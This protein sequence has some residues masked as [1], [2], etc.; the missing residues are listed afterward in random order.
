[1]FQKCLKIA[2]GPGGLIFL[3][4]V[5]LCPINSLLSRL[6]LLAGLGA[7]YAWIVRVC[8]RRYRALRYGILAVP[9]A[10]GLLTVMPGR[11]VDAER[12]RSQYITA[13]RSCEGRRYVWGGEGRLGIDCSGLA[14]RAWRDALLAEYAY[15]FNGSLLRG[16]LEHWWFDASARALGQGYRGYTVPTGRRGVIRAMS[17]TEL[18][19]GDLAVTDS[20]LHVLVF[21]GDE[22]WI[23]ATIPPGR[24]IVQ[25][26]RRGRSSW[27]DKP[28]TICRWSLLC[29]RDN[30][31]DIEGARS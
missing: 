24:V 10:L 18:K 27:F 29:P 9:V 16:I 19:P 3:G 4:V 31:A 28:V 30:G 8:W 11:P 14:R 15:T 25:D 23:Q 13:L 1:M 12:L 6:A 2:L 20:G 21:V 7:V 26:G 22:D 17:Y 5:M